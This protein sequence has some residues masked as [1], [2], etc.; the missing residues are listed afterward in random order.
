MIFTLSSLF[1]TAQNTK[2][3]Q[4]LF[5]E[6]KSTIKQA[7]KPIYESVSNL[8]TLQNRKDAALRNKP[9]DVVALECFECYGSGIVTSDVCT[10][11]KDW[12]NEYRSKVACNT[13]RDTRRIKKYNVW[14]TTCVNYS[15]VLYWP[16]NGTMGW[17]NLN[18]YT[19][20]V[21]KLLK[22]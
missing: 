22:Y 19:K 13:C 8:P 10:N 14:C 20:S 16:K 15:G 17:N 21:N 11:C 6:A 4:D 9:V 12:N 5:E 18:N 1:V 7:I 2:K 3:I